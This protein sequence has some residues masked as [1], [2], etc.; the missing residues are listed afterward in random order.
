MVDERI[1][2]V[3]VPVN[4]APDKFAFV[5]RMFCKFVT[6]EI[7]WVCILSANKEF[8]FVEPEIRVD[9]DNVFEEKEVE[10][11]ILKFEVPDTDRLSIVSAVM[12]TVGRDEVPPVK[13]LIPFWTSVCPVVAAPT[14]WNIEY[15]S[16]EPEIRVEAERVVTE[17]TDELTCP[18]NV[19]PDKFAFVDNWEFILLK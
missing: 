14:V 3:S 12:L 16:V 10:Y 7:L 15:K 4:V 13:V 5:L 8:I 18:V 6:S 17:I 1:G 9:A 2:V 19:A 11:K